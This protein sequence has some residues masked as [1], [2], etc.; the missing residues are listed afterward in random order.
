MA[1]NTGKG[2]RVGAVKN[3]SEFR[4]PNG[5]YVKRDTT[6]GRILNVEQAASQGCPGREVAAAIR[7][8]PGQ[9]RRGSGRVCPVRMPKESFEISARDTQ[10]T[11][12]RDAGKP[13]LASRGS[14]LA[15]GG[16]RGVSA[17]PQDRGGFVDGQDFG[18][19]VGLGGGHRGLLGRWGGLCLRRPLG[20]PG[21]RELSQIP[22][23]CSG[24]GWG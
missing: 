10:G 1:K 22:T 18:R 9:D 15:C 16:V 14:P 11:A 19:G 20:W 12:D 13:C 2:S 4:H 7:Y 5:T 6:T 23:A 8:R 24:A 21:L 17:D 3:R